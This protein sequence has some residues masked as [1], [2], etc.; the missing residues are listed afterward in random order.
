[1]ALQVLIPDA[2][3]DGPPEVETAVAREMGLDVRYDVRRVRH[4]AEVADD[5]W[6]MIDGLQVYHDVVVD[7]A[8]IGRMARCRIICR[9]GV[10]TDNIDLA[11]AAARGIPVC[12]VPDYG[13]TDVADSAI[14]MLLALR[15]GIG[16]H[17]GRLLRDPASHWQ[18]TPGPAVGRLRDSRFGVVGA[19]RIGQAVLRRARALD[20]A[21]GFYDPFLA[22][23]ADQAIGC[24]RFATL[25]DLLGWADAVSLHTPLTP[26]TRRLMDGAALA[27]MRPGA[28]LINTARGGCVDLDALAAALGSGH[29]AGA[30]LDVLP[31]E[32]P[33]G[34]PLL[35]AYAAREPWLDGRLVLTP[36]VAFY[37]ADSVR[38][39][40]S[41]ASR[42]VLDY[43][44]GGQ[45]AGQA[46]NCVNG[47]LLAAATA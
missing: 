5:V 43:L 12:N 3:Y 13:T 22:D 18:Q 19:G 23:G 17:H 34:H 31:V 24:E 32:P 26:A 29:L 15:R 14:G 35:A 21:T 11:A 42:A 38:D 36:H 4:A 30:A 25:H 46:R 20:M 28:V 2:K 41:K 7:Q 40:R 6:G 1:M 45:A 44:S 16:F 8:L 37:S 9:C 27:A 39:I 10:G 33:A 47:E